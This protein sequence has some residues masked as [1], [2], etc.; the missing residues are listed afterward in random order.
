VTD[1]AGTPAAGQVWDAAAYARH[2]AFV[3]ALGA[4]LLELLAPQPG[5]TILDLGCGDGALTTRLAAAGARVTGLEPDPDLAAAARA[6]GVS[7]VAQDAHDPFGTAAY[8]AVFSNAA[9][10]W[11]R[12]PEV[13]L[14]NI[15]QALR[16]GGRLVAEQGGFGNVA[17]I[18]TALNAAR[19]AQGH[20]AVFPW[21]FPS[22]E[23]QTARLQAAGFTVT[24]VALIP[25]PTPLPT[26]LRGWLDTFAGPFLADLPAAARAPLLDDSARRLA[27]LHDPAAGWVADY[28]RLRF[29]ARRAD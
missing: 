14:A 21:D 28:V 11:M 16:P 5:E 15:A 22:P 4:E 20:A 26:G 1:A 6:R 3:P 18:V 27:A 10:H 24:E 7:V 17:A 29:A 25:R 23:R 2:A 13:V 8:D 12:A 9:L 19:E